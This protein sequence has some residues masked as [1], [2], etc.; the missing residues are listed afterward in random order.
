MS[1]LTFAKRDPKL[2]PRQIRAQGSIPVTVYGKNLKES[3]SLQ[4]SLADYKSLHLSQS[5]QSIEGQIADEKTQHLVLIKSIEKHPVT[6]VVQNIQFQKVE[7]NQRVKVT[8]PII[9]EGS[10]PLVQSGGTLSLNKKL[11]DLTCPAKDI[12]QNIKFDLATL[13]DAKSIAYYSDLPI[14]S[15]ISLRSSAEQII[16]KVSMPQVSKD[17]KAA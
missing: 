11:V 17:A 5:V 16:A 8:V 12:P 10:S 3:L 1:S 15:G 9:Y 2:N 7:P 14:P 13:K 4:I 6:G